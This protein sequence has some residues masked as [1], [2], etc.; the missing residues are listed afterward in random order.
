MISTG[1]YGAPRQLPEQC[2]R[3]ARENVGP[4]GAAKLQ[5]GGARPL[6]VR[7]EDVI[8]GELQSVVRLDGAAQINVAAVIERPAAVLRLPRTQVVG[9]LRLERGV[10]LVQKVHHHDVL[11]GDGAVRLELV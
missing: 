3:N 2:Q 11:G 5:Y 8:A 7:R 10:D 4:R 1:I 9:D 6:H